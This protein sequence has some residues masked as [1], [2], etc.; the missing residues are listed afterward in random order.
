MDTI[1][2]FSATELARLCRKRT[3][4][5]LDALLGVGEIGF[6]FGPPKLGKTLLGLDLALHLSLGEAWLST[7]AATQIPVLYLSCDDPL[8]RFNKRLKDFRSSYGYKNPTELY[9][10][11]HPFDL[12]NSAH[13]QQIENLIK[14]KKA[15][16]L[17]LDVWAHMTPGLDENSAKEVNAVLVPLKFMARRLGCTVLIVDHST[18]SQGGFNSLR[19]STAKWAA[20]DCLLRLSPGGGKGLLKLHRQHKDFGVADPLLLRVSPAG[21]KQPKFQIV[22]SPKQSTGTKRQRSGSKATADKVLAVMTIGRRMQ[23]AVIRQKTA[24][25]E[26]T[27]TRHLGRLVRQGRVKD[28]GNNRNRTYERLY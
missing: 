7:F 16:L 1:K 8:S 23:K 6:L 11:S 12:T 25:P 4:A 13:L 2:V 28:H 9:F 21:S 17:I 27:L 18:K 19:G 20:A 5:L 22:G 10:A 3:A 14:D 15:G 24:M 26:R